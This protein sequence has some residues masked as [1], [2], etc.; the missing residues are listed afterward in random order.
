MRRLIPTTILTLLLFSSYSQTDTV[1]TKKQTGF[2]FLSAYHYLYDY[3]GG[4][5]RPE[6]FPDFFYPSKDNLREAFLSDTVVLSN[7]MRI[8]G[9]I[10][11]RY[12]LKR[13][14]KIVYGRD[15]TAFYKY[16][17]FYLVPVVLDYKAYRDDWPLLRN[18]N[19][20]EFTTRTGSKIKFEYRNEAAVITRLTELHRKARKVQKH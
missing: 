20:Y 19:F 7:G 17:S 18:R 16:D 11:G 4:H 8:E 10:P 2:L 9:L 5:I 6:G 3:E 13:S 14:A 1:I 12:G 15:A